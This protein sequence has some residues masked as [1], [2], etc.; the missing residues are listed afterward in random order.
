MLTWEYLALI[1]IKAWKV[2]LLIFNFFYYVI[3]L[4]RLTL[5]TFDFKLV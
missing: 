4:L 5:L 2:L 3:N 1:L